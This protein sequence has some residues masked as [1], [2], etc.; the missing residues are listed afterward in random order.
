MFLP[1]S[2]R[3]ASEQAWKDPMHGNEHGISVL[4]LKCT[5]IVIRDHEAKLGLRSD[6]LVKRM[7]DRLHGLCSS[8]CVQHVTLLTLGNQKIL[9]GWNVLNTELKTKKKTRSAGP[10]VRWLFLVCIRFV[11][12]LNLPC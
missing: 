9:K 12:G 6:T 3:V 5:V 2:P 4:I 8:P 10:S 7:S 11:P 1:G